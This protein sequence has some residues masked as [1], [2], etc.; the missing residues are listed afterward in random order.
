LVAW[1]DSLT[2]G[3]GTTG[4]SLSADAYPYRLGTL[5]HLGTINLGVGGE[6]ST[7]IKTRLLA[8]ATSVWSKP[9]IIW[10]GRNNFSAPATVKADIAAMV[11]S[12]GH[13]NYIVLSVLNGS[14]TTEWAGQSDYITITQLNADLAA[15]YG[16][17]YLDV[18]SY[19]VSLYDAAQPQDVIDHGHDV[20]PA[21][22]RFDGIHLNNAGYQ[23]VANYIYANRSLLGVS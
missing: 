18:R 8:A 7:Q 19:L 3:T 17:R 11:A 2:A 12:L 20:P 6:S 14:G 16:A 13:T 15:T 4:G 5:L 9:T 10:A 1:G 22:L 23:A 21:S